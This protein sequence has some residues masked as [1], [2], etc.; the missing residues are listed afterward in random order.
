LPEFL[1]ATGQILS[2]HQPDRGHKIASGSINAR[3]YYGA[4]V[5]PGTYDADPGMVSTRWLASFARCCV[6]IRF[7][8]DPINVCTALKLRRQHNGA[9]PRIDRQT[10]ILLDVFRQRPAGAGAYR[11]R[12]VAMKSAAEVQAFFSVRAT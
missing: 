9:R 10:C 11:G 5:A 6:L 8:I 3:I 2:R 4:A 12:P 7:S 1:L